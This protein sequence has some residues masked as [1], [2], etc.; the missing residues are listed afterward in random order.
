M[1]RRV[2]ALLATHLL[3][4]AALSLNDRRQRLVGSFDPIL[5]SQILFVLLELVYRLIAVLVCA[6]DG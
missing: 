2:H 5:S 6:S 3:L 1:H 4:D